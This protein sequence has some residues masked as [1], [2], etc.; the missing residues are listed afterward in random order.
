MAVEYSIIKLIG[1][2]RYADVFSAKYNEQVV[3]L[4]KIYVRSNN[5][6]QVLREIDCLQNIDNEFVVKLHH[7]YSE[8]NGTTVLVFELLKFTLLQVI[9]N[10]KPLPENLIEFWS[11]QLFSGLESIHQSGMVHRDVKPQNLLFNAE[12]TIKFID[13]GQA[14]FIEKNKEQNVEENRLTNGSF[15]GTRW[16]KPIELLYG[17]EKYGPEIDVWSLG[18][19]LAEMVRGEALFPGNSDIIQLCLIQ[20][21]LGTP[22]ENQWPEVLQLPDYGKLIFKPSEGTGLDVKCGE[23]LK[24]LIQNCLRI[25]PRERIKPSEVRELN[26]GIEKNHEI[27]PKQFMD[28]C[29]ERM[30][31]AEKEGEGNGQNFCE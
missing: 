3:A 26:W 5:K 12:G 13:F 22:D 9:E 19:I 30:L 17:G 10:C 6:K 4:K 18:C 28:K 15:L 1:N 27:N 24:N 8:N 20:N 11:L 23:R 31:L 16:Y 25:T 7:N 2:G 14:R 21:I 29:Q